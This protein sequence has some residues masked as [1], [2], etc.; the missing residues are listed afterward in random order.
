MAESHNAIHID[1]NDD[2]LSQAIAENWPGDGTSSNPFIIEGYEIYSQEFCIEILNTDV[3]FQVKNCFLSSFGSST[4]G[5]KLDQV[6]KGSIENNTINNGYYGIL[7]T[8]FNSG[9]NVLKN[10]IIENVSLGMVFENGA[11]STNT[12]H[13]QIRDVRYSGI[14]IQNE[15]TG[16]LYNNRIEN[17]GD[18]GI[19]I[20]GGEYEGVTHSIDIKHNIIRNNN[21]HGIDIKS[22]PLNIMFNNTIDG[23]KESGISIGD[24]RGNLIYNNTIYNNQASGILLTSSENSNI[25]FN[26]IFENVGGGIYVT[27]SQKN[28]F[29]GNII[30]SNIAT[31]IFVDLS[32]ENNFTTNILSNGKNEGMYIVRSDRNMI[33]ENLF[34]NARYGGVLLEYNSSNNIISFNDFTDNA[35]PYQQAAD[36]SLTTTNVFVYNY[37]NDWA[38]PDLNSDGF[39]DS[40]Y[41]IDENKDPY[42]LTQL[43]LNH[44]HRILPPKLISPTGGGKL[45][46]TVYINWTLSVD[47][48]KHP[49]NYNL[50]YSLD[51]GEN[52]VEIKSN[53][54]YHYYRWDTTEVPNSDTCLLK[55]IASCTGECEASDILDQPVII[56]NS[57]VA[58][59][60]SLGFDPNF[61]KILGDILPYALIAI[62]FVGL[63]YYAITSQLKRSKSFIEY[64]Q[65]DK[66]EFLRPLYHKVIIA[67]ENVQLGMITEQDSTP[68]LEPRELTSLSVDYFPANIQ[69]DLRLKLKGRT[70][71]TLIEIAY[72]DPEVMNPVK[73][74]H[75]LNIPPSTLSNDIKRLIDL[76]YLESYIS[77]Q[78]MEDGRFRTYSITLKGVSFLRILKGALELS[79]KQAKTQIPSI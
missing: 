70:V 38:S 52:W 54:L 43:D 2:F 51:N 16:S 34:W 29:Q 75:I 40:P 24:L 23:N 74:A 58:S 17:C 48:H 39:V 14:T 22:S 63:G 7:V 64:I 6:I 53:L 62:V 27:E 15:A 5:I 46:G 66:L 26:Y 20:V 42:P 33:S 59:Q 71:L 61:N 44:E 68:L 41:T 50:F 35:V 77:S 47:S 19:L 30:N 79:I 31:D 10:N 21:E 60:N 4:G 76:G 67:L 57:L 9:G 28:V 13:N 37:W 3:Y 73:L 18:S 45:G 8:N 49:V 56:Q 1:G 65:S 78:V 69:K 25:S 12:S 36:N 72:Q 55:I 11:M 32:E